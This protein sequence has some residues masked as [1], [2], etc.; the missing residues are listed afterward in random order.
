MH[1]EVQ[2]RR[3]V[4][5][6]TNANWR[7]RR[8]VSGACR[9][10]A[11]RPSSAMK[12]KSQKLKRRHGWRE[13]RLRVTGA[14]AVDV[15]RGADIVAKGKGALQN[16]SRGGTLIIVTFPKGTSIDRDDHL[17]LEVTSG[18]FKGLM[19]GG[20]VRRFI[21][22]DDGRWIFGVEFFAVG[23]DDA[24]IL[25]DTIRSLQRRPRKR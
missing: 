11:Q 20:R 8:S 23:G 7:G 16:L 2:R 21:A 24:A 13:P 15:R 25:I 4:V 10:G 22:E 18:P 9:T 14:V 19:V 5:N 17:E 1:H 6:D 3:R 12:G